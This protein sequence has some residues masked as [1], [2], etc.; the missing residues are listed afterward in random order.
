MTTING[1]SCLVET[2]KFG[3]F[4]TSNSFLSCLKYISAIPSIVLKVKLQVMSRQFQPATAVHFFDCLW[5]HVISNINF[6]GRLRYL[7]IHGDDKCRC[8][9]CTKELQPRLYYAIAVNVIVKYAIRNKI[10]D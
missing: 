6:S 7:Q 5:S 9:R 1:D 3:K 2:E 4:I 10:Q 8:D